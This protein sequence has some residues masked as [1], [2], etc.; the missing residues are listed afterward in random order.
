VAVVGEVEGDTNDANRNKV[1]FGGCN[2]AYM[3]QISIR[4]ETSTSVCD[5]SHCPVPG[6]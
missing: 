5:P 4:I 6:L 3:S 2:V 1:N